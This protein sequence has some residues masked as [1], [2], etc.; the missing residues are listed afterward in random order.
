MAL[1]NKNPSP[2]KTQTQ[3]P[4]A[5]PSS[6]GTPAQVGG[7]RPLKTYLT[8]VQTA[9][10]EQKESIAKI[11]LAERERREANKEK[12]PPHRE[13]SP[14]QKKM[15]VIAGSVLGIVVLVGGAW[16][17]LRFFNIELNL[18][19]TGEPTVEVKQKITS[20]SLIPPSHEK[21]I[22]VSGLSYDAL[23]TGVNTEVS[24]ERGAQ[25]VL[26]IFFTRGK[27]EPIEGVSLG[28]EMLTAPM[29]FSLFLPQ[30]P[31]IL[32]RSLAPAFMV[33]VY[34]DVAQV[35]HP[36]IILKVTSFESSLAGM[37][38]WEKTMSYDIGRLL[39]IR[40]ED[41]QGF[42][43]IVIQNK[44]T[45]ALLDRSREPVLIYSFLDRTTILIT[46]DRRTFGD[47]LPLVNNL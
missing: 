40:T 12:E 45:R 6:Q 26:N 18:P 47:V 24:Q 27:M 42:K 4:P 17:A 34:H 11:A 2:P 22:D 20:P 39:G 28:K 16:G 23:V 7:I 36:F 38:A 3:T 30:A 5:K 37:L 8:D 15:F 13:F 25:S 10:Q 43:D 1:E 35:G 44:D 21:E 29:F 19:G 32:A 33:G 46:P 31:E 41:T 14:Q 9:I